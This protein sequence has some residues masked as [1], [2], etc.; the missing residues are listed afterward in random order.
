M[1]GS[2]QVLADFFAGDFS[3]M[4]TIVM[5]IDPR[6][7]AASGDRISAPLRAAARPGRAGVC[8]RISAPLRAA[9]RPGRAGACDQNGAP[10]RAAARPEAA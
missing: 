9:V 6:A 7:R 5:P 10:L 3:T 8:D 1:Q 2:E 4:R